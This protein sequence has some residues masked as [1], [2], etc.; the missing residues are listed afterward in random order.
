MCRRNLSKVLANDKNVY[1][2]IDS[3]NQNAIVSAPKLYINISPSSKNEPSE[4]PLPE[5]LIFLK[6]ID[7][8]FGMKLTSSKFD[9]WVVFTIC[10]TVFFCLNHRNSKS[11]YYSGCQ[12]YE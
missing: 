3:K 4:K 8:M 6:F 2:G 11:R 12:L 5:L 9:L 1:A 10:A 7:N